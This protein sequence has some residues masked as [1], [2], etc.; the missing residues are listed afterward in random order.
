MKFYRAFFRCD[1]PCERQHDV[2]VESDGWPEMNSEIRFKCPDLGTVV[3]RPS[4]AWDEVE[5]EPGG[6]LIRGQLVVTPPRPR[7]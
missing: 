5:H 3:R 2:W 6:D 7:S 4:S 1:G